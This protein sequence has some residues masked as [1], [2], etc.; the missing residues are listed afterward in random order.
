MLPIVLTSRTEYTISTESLIASPGKH[1]IL[2]Q[3]AEKV[4]SL[5]EVKLGERKSPVIN[6]AWLIYAV[7][8]NIKQK[9]FTATSNRAQPT[10]HATRRELQNLCKLSGCVRF[11]KIVQENPCF[12]EDEVKIF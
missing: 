8:D 6:Q 4:M 7:T 5:Q 9:I 12:G 3:R 1:S 10:A 2:T 11:K